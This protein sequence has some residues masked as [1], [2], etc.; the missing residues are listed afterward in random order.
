MPNTQKDSTWYY[1][2][3]EINQLVPQ[4]NKLN[5]H[6]LGWRAV[7]ANEPYRD[8]FGES[9]DIGETFYQRQI[10]AAA[11]DVIRLSK[12]SMARLLYAAFTANP[13]LSDLTEQMSEVREQKQNLFTKRTQHIAKGV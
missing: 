2:D 6:H 5:P 12:I 4:L 10:G 13:V 1:T 7:L 11:D 9:I 8:D 3:E